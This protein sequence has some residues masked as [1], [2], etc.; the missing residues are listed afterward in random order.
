MIVN[1]YTEILI[2]DMTKFCF[3][4]YLIISSIPRTIR[5][6]SA[7][8]DETQDLGQSQGQKRH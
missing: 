6:T 3:K 2:F 8:E 4:S 1:H 5:H 7:K